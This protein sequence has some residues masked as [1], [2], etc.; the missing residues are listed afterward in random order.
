MERTRRLDLS[1]FSS[2][3]RSS[4]DSIDSGSLET[5]AALLLSETDTLDLSTGVLIESFILDDLQDSDSLTM[6]VCGQTVHTLSQW[7]KVQVDCSRS[8]FSY[9]M[10]GDVGEYL[11]HSFSESISLYGPAWSMRLGVAGNMSDTQSRRNDV[12]NSLESIASDLIIAE[13]NG[14][15]SL[16]FESLPHLLATFG[17]NAVDNLMTSIDEIS[18][19]GVT[20][21]FRIYAFRAVFIA[22]DSFD[23]IMI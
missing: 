16:T 7:D 3:F 15:N 14:V 6:K 20:Y 13:G 8:G 23:P 12:Y 5:F 22:I 9:E 21:T 19:V 1:G 18:Q 10:D 11:S 17:T 2:L 4:F